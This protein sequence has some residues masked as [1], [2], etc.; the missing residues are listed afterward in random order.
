MDVV[1]AGDIIK[2]LDDYKKGPFSLSTR[3]STVNLCNLDGEI[4]NVQ[5]DVNLFIRENYTLKE[6]ENF[7]IKK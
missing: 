7:L 4:Y 6:Y 3:V 2:R 5:Q 1:H